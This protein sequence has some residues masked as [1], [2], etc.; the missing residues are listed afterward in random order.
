MRVKKENQIV[1]RCNRRFCK[2]SVNKDGMTE[3]FCRHFNLNPEDVKIRSANGTGWIVDTNNGSYWV[4]TKDEARRE[5][6]SDIIDN[7]KGHSIENTPEFRNAIESGW[8]LDNDALRDMADLYADDSGDMD[9]EDLHD[10]AYNNFSVE[11][12]WDQNLI[13]KEALC[14]HVLDMN[15]YG[16]Q[17]DIEGVTDDETVNGETYY[18]IL[19]NG[20]RDK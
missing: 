12:L 9:E 14:E 5:A 1:R 15:G 18:F 19:I 11:E 20:K 16:T 2:E 8:C 10:W 17:L 6:I 13:D 3:I 7:F 4:L